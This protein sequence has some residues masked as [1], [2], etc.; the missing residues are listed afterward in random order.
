MR[1]VIVSLAICLVSTVVVGIV[2]ADAVSPPLHQQAQ[3]AQQT[4]GWSTTVFKNPH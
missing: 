3:A 4:G 2:M 1:A